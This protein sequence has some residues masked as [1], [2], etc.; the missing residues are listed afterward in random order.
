LAFL[1]GEHIETEIYR[2]STGAFEAGPNLDRV[3]YAPC[4]VALS[5]TEI[6]YTGGC[7]GSNYAEVSYLWVTQT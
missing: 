7:D 1:G 6:I 5:A 4:G 3:K 2:A